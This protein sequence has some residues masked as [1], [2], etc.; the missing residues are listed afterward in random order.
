MSK[1]RSSI[2]RAN[3]AHGT[4]PRVLSGTQSINKTKTALNCGLDFVSRNCAS[5]RS[6]NIVKKC[7]ILCCENQAFYC[8][9]FLSA[10]ANIR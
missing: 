2:G 9:L 1:I 6:K 7:S 4:S 5:S 3:L 10:Y 8:K